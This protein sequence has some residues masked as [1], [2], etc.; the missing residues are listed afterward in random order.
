MTTGTGLEAGDRAP[1]FTLVDDAGQ[2]FLFYEFATGDPV[3]LLAFGGETAPEKIET[4]LSDLNRW[5]QQKPDVQIIALK[6]GDVRENAEL[7]ERLDLLFPLLSDE[8]RKVGQAL[9]GAAHGRSDTLSALILDRNLRVID[10]LAPET[11]QAL[12]AALHE[13]EH[14]MAARAASPAMTAAMTAPV[15]VI[16][17]VL[18]QDLCRTLIDR[19]NSW[20]PKPSP[21]PSIVDGKIT[22]QV[23]EARKSRLDVLPG[24]PAVVERLTDLI[25]RR[26]LPELQKAFWYRVTRFEQ[27]KLVAYE[28]NSGGH[29][30]VHRDNTA[31]D[32]AHRR[33]ALTLNL[34]T[35]AYEGGGLRFPEYGPTVYAPAPGAAIVFSGSH[36]HEVLPVT[37]GTRY[38]LITFLSG[39]DVPARPRGP[40]P[41][42]SPQG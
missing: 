3:V 38:A 30:G 28:E 24:D 14:T 12:T 32:T 2:A 16:P 25:A 7:A 29:F 35:D 5:W 34:N 22:M 9:F 36:A 23:D 11:A 1:N 21:M 39:D 20:D 27:V 4:A 6:T 13:A 41:E 37:K 15:L 26:V 33:F 17:D 40:A 8:D 10:R 42:P 19:F 31:P 18:P